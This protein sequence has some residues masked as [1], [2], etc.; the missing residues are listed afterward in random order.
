MLFIFYSEWSFF[1]GFSYSFP[2]SYRCYWIETH[3]VLI[4]SNHCIIYS[5]LEKNKLWSWKG[6]INDNNKIAEI[7]CSLNCNEIC[8]HRIT[9]NIFV[10]LHAMLAHSIIYL[11]LTVRTASMILTFTCYKLSIRKNSFIAPSMLHIH[12][13]GMSFNQSVN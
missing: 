12:Q 7:V 11:L 4:V 13:I 5:N 2:F 10:G 1:D 3:T 6:N 8:C 9:V